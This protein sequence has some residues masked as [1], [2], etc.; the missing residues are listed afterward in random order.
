MDREMDWHD[1]SCFVEFHHLLPVD[2]T[3]LVVDLC[4]HVEDSCH[5]SVVHLVNIVLILRIGTNKEALIA[6]LVKVAAAYEVCVNLFDMPIHKEHLVDVVPLKKTFIR[7]GF[8]L[9]FH[10]LT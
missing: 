6:Y 8:V 7:D 10:H 5:A 4:L 3:M 2:S 1:I 9:S